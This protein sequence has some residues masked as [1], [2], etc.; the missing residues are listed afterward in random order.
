MKETTV[1][2]SVNNRRFINNE[3]RKMNKHCCFCVTQ[4]FV[5]DIALKRYRKIDRIIEILKTDFWN[6]NKIESISK[7]INS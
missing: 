3:V 7:I 1:K 2:C 4:S 5:L 6:K